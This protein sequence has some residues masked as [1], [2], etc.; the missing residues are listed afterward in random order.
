MEDNLALLTLVVVL[1]STVLNSWYPWAYH[2]WYSVTYST[3][4]SCRH[5]LATQIFLYDFKIFLVDIFLL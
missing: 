4:S 2:S 5:R 3:T 1:D